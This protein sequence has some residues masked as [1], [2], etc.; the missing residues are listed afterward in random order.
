MDRGSYLRKRWGLGPQVMICS[1]VLAG[2]LITLPH[3]AARAAG[4]TLVVRPTSAPYSNQTIKVTG[5]SY[6]PGEVV[7]VY[8]NYS[9][10]GTGILE[11]SRTTDATGA[12]SLQ[13]KI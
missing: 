5:A 9:G 6:G 1:L 11:A 10:P 13:I 3:Y 7:K 8:W 2:V 12:F 4:A